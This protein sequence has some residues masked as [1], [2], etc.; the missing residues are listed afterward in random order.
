MQTNG[1]TMDRAP[2][3]G[4]IIN[5]LQHGAF[6]K[7]GRVIGGGSL[8]A[9]RIAAGVQFYWRV[10]T[11][12]KTD[13]M[14]I[15]FYD[16]LASP[17]STEKTE[18]GFSVLAAD[19]EAERMAKEHQKNADVGGLR[20]VKKAEKHAK[21][22]A[23][24][25][26][27]DKLLTDYCDHLQTLGRS[28]YR[29]AR[30]IFK[31]HVRDAWPGLAERPAAKITTED[32]ADMMRKLME[33][34][35]GRTANKLRSYMRAAFQTAKAARTKASIP[36]H[37]KDFGIT[38][39]PAAETEADE[40]HNVPDKR[41]LTAAELCEY[42]S[43]IKA[44]PGLRGALLRLHLLTGGQRIEQLVNL[45]TAAITGQ[46]M[47]LLDGKGR[48]GR[49]P[50]PHSVPLTKL[51][52]QALKDCSPSGAFAL[53]TDDGETHIA[54]TTLSN[55]AAAAAGDAIPEFQAKRVRSGV[56]TLLASV[57]VSQDI[58]GRLQSHGVS[59]VQAR[60]YDAYDY[61]VEKLAALK[62]LEHVLIG[63][64]KSRRPAKAA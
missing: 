53:S 23:Q 39:N 56:E 35:K 62:K 42:W 48:P 18:R 31:L 36:V 60:H 7:L 37:F 45:R 27:L 9:R 20:A 22:A 51:A 30:S 15:G 58:R 32:V 2:T 3:P 49:A 38:M 57:G 41:P 33:Q 52:A 10:T 64:A 24:A 28:S 59:G 34:G 50:R 47:T 55:W 40:A 17:K 44:L 5:R 54:A 11:A 63:P 19:R 14:P 4:Q 6:V 25:Q 12:G 13:R 8:E 1:L 46:G 26:T 21:V 43:I 16:S 29:D 61:L